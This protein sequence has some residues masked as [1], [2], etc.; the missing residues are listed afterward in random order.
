M[1]NDPTANPPQDQT[2]IPG[3][4]PPPIH[5]PLPPA[6][7]ASAGAPPPW[8]PLPPRPA[9][10]GSRI[11]PILL[12]LFMLFGFGFL[13]L[14]LVVGFIFGRGGGEF[15]GRFG[16][17]LAA[18]G[19]SIALV[20][21]EG[22]IMPGPQYDFWMKTLDE[23]ADNAGIKGIL[24]RINSPGGSVA[25]SQELYDRILS[26]RAGEGLGGSKK[27]YVSMGDLAASGGYYI[28]AAADRIIANRGSLTGSIGVISTS[29]KIDK[30]AEDH[31]V[32]FEVIKTGRFKDAGSM[33]RPTTDE[34][35]KMFDTLLNDAYD[36]F[37]TDVLSQRDAQIAKAYTSFGKDDWGI[38]QFTEPANGTSRDF[39][40]QVAD[41]RVY[42]GEQALKLGLV[43]ELGSL[44]HALKLLAKDLRIKGRPSIY[45]PRQRMG[46][47]DLLETRVK[48]V[49]PSANWAHSTLQYRMIPF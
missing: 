13:A 16:G 47:F 25:A 49:V 5:P 3:P 36:Q 45:E 9:K 6:G 2:Q 21:L 40:K 42:S 43:D 24:L 30:L 14:I 8:P 34:E 39:L 11:L 23:I 10:K 18:K 29:I 19:S 32:G 38:F 20:K 27:V 22:P 7:Y 44:E 33:F 48:D 26:I 41:G 46:F 35:K 31:G 12:G 17:T 15:S 4:P 1:M 37:L 28:A